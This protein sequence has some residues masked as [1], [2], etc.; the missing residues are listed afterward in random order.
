MVT[1]VVEPT[2]GQLFEASLQGDL[3]AWNVLVDRLSPVIW[4]AA[5]SFGLSPSQA[6]DVFQT[7]WLRLWDRQDTI[8]N[9]EALPGWIR[10]TA[11]NE[12]L[13]LVKRDGRARPV[14][15]IEDQNSTDLAPAD[16]GPE[17]LIEQEM[18]NELLWAGFS[19]LDAR[20]QQLLRLLSERVPLSEVG[21]ALSMPVGSIGPTRGRCLNKLRETPEVRRLSGVAL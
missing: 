4:S 13:A 16:P 7:V 17:D 20:C 11:R 21:E 12:A 2:H 15:D 3:D 9:P 18:T 5:Q 19:R 10:T 14:E 1:H 8:K 6:E